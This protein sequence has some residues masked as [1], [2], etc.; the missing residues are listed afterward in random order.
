MCKNR[1]YGPARQMRWDQGGTVLILT[2]THLLLALDVETLVVDDA[3]K[4]FEVGQ[5]V[6]LSELANLVES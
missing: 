6:E 4:L 2:L 3:S 1:I 5:L